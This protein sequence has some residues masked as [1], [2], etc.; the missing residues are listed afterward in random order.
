MLLLKLICHSLTST[1]Y[2]FVFFFPLPSV[3]PS[4]LVSR[5]VDVHLL[6]K[7]CFVVYKLLFSRFCVVSVA[8][9]VK[10]VMCF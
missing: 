2:F 5:Y 4:R 9:S 7:L 10:Y 1:R 3:M 6:R 8:S